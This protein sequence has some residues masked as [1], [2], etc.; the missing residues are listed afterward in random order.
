MIDEIG[1]DYEKLKAKVVASVSNKV[2]Q[3]GPVPMDVGKVE[4]GYG[5]ENAYDMDGVRHD[6]VCY[7]CG[8]CGHISQFCS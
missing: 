2:E 7:S 6:I 5:E 8:G 4:A 1:E 3:Q